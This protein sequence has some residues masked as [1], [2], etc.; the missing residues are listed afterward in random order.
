MFTR[1]HASILCEHARVPTHKK[2]PPSWCGCALRTSHES[3]HAGARTC[4]HIFNAYN[5]FEALAHK[6]NTHAL[7]GWVCCMC[8]VYAN[9]SVCL[10]RLYVVFA[11]RSLVR[12]NTMHHNHHTQH[13]QHAR[14]TCRVQ[15]HAP[16]ARISAIHKH[17][18]S[19][20]VMRTG[21]SAMEC[22][23]AASGSSA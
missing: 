22:K 10:L 5:S 6:H 17:N 14:V 11:L 7:R 20:R 15:N 16:K 19:L 23:T 1:A 21:H 2:E 8:V 12:T 9:M 4:I 13:T 3:C 18:T